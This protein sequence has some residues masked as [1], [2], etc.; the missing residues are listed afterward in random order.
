[1][2][3]FVAIYL[4]LHFI[5]S[6]G[7]DPYLWGADSWGYFSPFFAI[8]FLVVGILSVVPS[9]KGKAA[10]FL[11]ALSK[12]VVKV[13]FWLYG[14]VFAAV[15]YALRSATYFLGDGY[16][17]IRN[18]EKGAF[19][20]ASEPLDT[21]FH[22]ILY[23]LSN[24]A[25]GFTGADVYAFVSLLCGAT[26][27]L[28]FY[29]YLRK[30][31][32]DSV[33]AFLATSIVSLSGVVQ[34]FFGYVESYSLAAV[35]L[36]LFV[37]SSY[38]SIKLEK[39]SVL[40]A[41]L[42][43]VALSLHSQSIFFLPAL[44]YCYW[45]AFRK[46]KNLGKLL[47]SASALLFVVAFSLWIVSLYTGQSVLAEYLETAG[48][49]AFLPVFGGE[50]GYGI[51][52]SWH[53]ID[54]LNEIILILP[55]IVAVPFVVK[56][57]GAKLKREDVFLLVASAFYFVFMLIFNP[58]LGF[59]RDWDLFSCFAIPVSLFFSIVIVKNEKNMRTALVTVLVVSFLHTLPFVIVNS[60]EEYSLKRAES[61]A[62]F[63]QFSEKAKA[64]LLDELSYYYRENKRYKDALRTSEK[65]YEFEKNNRYLFRNAMLKMRL[66][67]YEGAERDLRFLEENDYKLAEIYNYLGDI[68]FD[69]K[70]MPKADYYYSK[71]LKK[72]STIISAINNLGLINL[73]T[74]NY[75]ESIRHFK[76]SLNY[77]SKD[78]RLFYY[79][80]VCYVNLPNL[81]SAL[82]YAELAGEK[83]YKPQIVE[84]L[85]RLIKERNRREN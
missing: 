13:P 2:T 19:L 59:A 46:D 62:E 67:K 24:P 12:K 25:F 65:A 60:S 68:S 73:H 83:G 14:A 48:D 18:V 27:I 23:N 58:K 41:V 26:F 71:A 51:L 1:M 30:I 75:E 69:K 53:I 11:V 61:F 74:K 15:F 43:G 4:V 8:V 49:R 40:P 78:P 38:S 76:S 34:L 72:D 22:R 82:K 64:L 45:V 44:I 32:G 79:L 37:L 21:F 55:A 47:I 80:S 16:L 70:D 57:Y 50:S 42:Y 52:S 54:I 20:S 36:S 7:A 3:V 85:K 35:F 10:D 81:D 29:Y 31:L 39:L 28:A 6:F 84:S 17:R 77:Y 66:K 63:P 9:V 33:K 5:A 56:N